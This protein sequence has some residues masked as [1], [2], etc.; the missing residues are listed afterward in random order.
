MKPT[1]SQY[2]VVNGVWFYVTATFDS[3]ATYETDLSLYKDGVL[4][5]TGTFGTQ[6]ADILN[7]VGVIGASLKPDS[8][9]Q[10]YFNGCIYQIFITNTVR[11]LEDI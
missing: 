6:F 1:S 8:N 7:S 9:R 2:D 3:T 5:N 10:N 11:T 4:T